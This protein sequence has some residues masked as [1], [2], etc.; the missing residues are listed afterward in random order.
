MRRRHRTRSTT[1]RMWTSILFAELIR[2]EAAEFKR[3]KHLKLWSKA[4]RDNWL[5]LPN[6][7]VTS[8]DLCPQ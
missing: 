5:S 2:V 1:R 7:N 8:G 6:P 4:Q 3:L